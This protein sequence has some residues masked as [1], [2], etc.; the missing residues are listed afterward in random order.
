MQ[1]KTGVFKKIEK[2]DIPI[3]KFPDVEV[4]LDHEKIKERADE[5][6][7]ALLLGNIAH[8][9]IKI[10]FEDDNERRVVETT[11]WGVTDKRVILKQ[12]ILIPIKRIH[13]IKI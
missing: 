12:G 11:V 7:R 10:Y 1:M 3:L 9:K 5:L 13:L 6:N 2:E 8:A 4:L